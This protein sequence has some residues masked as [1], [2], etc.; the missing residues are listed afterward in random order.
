MAVFSRLRLENHSLQHIQNK[1]AKVIYL[2]PQ[3]KTL[4]HQKVKE[5]SAEN[6]LVLYVDIMKE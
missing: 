1:N 5:L 2:T 6:E 3:G 4:T